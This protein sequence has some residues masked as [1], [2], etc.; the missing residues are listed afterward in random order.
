M[1]VGIIILLGV[2]SCSLSATGRLEPDDIPYVDPEGELNAGHELLKRSFQLPSTGDIN[3]ASLLSGNM[4]VFGVL[5]HDDG[6]GTG[7]KR[8]CEGVLIDEQI[9]LTAQICVPNIPPTGPGKQKWSFTY[10]GQN[11]ELRDLHFF[12][13]PDNKFALIW[14]PVKLT[15]PPDVYAFP[16]WAGDGQSTDIK[17]DIREEFIDNHNVRLSSWYAAKATGDSATNANNIEAALSGCKVDDRDPHIAL[18]CALNAVCG[19]NLV[20]DGATFFKLA[21]TGKIQ[22]VA[23]MGMVI[24]G[25]SGSSCKSLDPRNSV[26]AVLP[27]IGSSRKRKRTGA[28]AGP[29]GKRQKLGNGGVACTDPYLCGIRFR[30]SEVNGIL[31][32]AKQLV[33]SSTKA[34]A[35]AAAGAP[36]PSVAASLNLH[37]DVIPNKAIIGTMNLNGVARLSRTMGDLVQDVFK[38]IFKEADVMLLQEVAFTTP[39][40]QQLQTDLAALGI[41]M[42]ALQGGLTCLYKSA[43]VQSATC[44]GVKLTPTS[45]HEYAQLCKI[46][47]VGKAECFHVFN[48]HLA[49]GIKQDR[50]DQMTDI[51]DRI[52]KLPAGTC[53]EVVLIAGDFNTISIEETERA[54]RSFGNV[55]LHD[56]GRTTPG[57]EFRAQ[58]ALPDDD[59]DGFDPLEINKEFHYDRVIVSES[60]R[61]LHQQFPLSYI[62]P[63]YKVTLE[64][65]SQEERLT[66]LRDTFNA[67]HPV[68]QNQPA[69]RS[70]FLSDH[71]PL[72]FT[73]QNDATFRLGTWNLEHFDPTNGNSNNVDDK[74]KKYNKEFTAIFNEFDVLAVQEIKAAYKKK[75]Q[76]V[77]YTAASNL[78]EISNT[79][80]FNRK[81]VISNKVP[82]LG[83]AYDASINV[84][85]CAN[86]D[87]SAHKY[88]KGTK[89]HRDG[90]SCDFTKN[91]NT[92][93]LVSVHVANEGSSQAAAKLYVNE[94][95]KDKSVLSYVVGD[96]NMNK[97]SGSIN[98]QMKDVAI[99][100]WDFTMAVSKHVRDYVWP[101]IDVNLQVPTGK[102]VPGTSTCAVLNPELAKKA[103]GTYVLAD[104]VPQS[105]MRAFTTWREIS[106]HYPVFIEF[107]S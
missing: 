88:K 65:F 82:E 105:R 77:A 29:G 26:T 79:N 4:K 87:M 45:T 36:K 56:P 52:D 59:E 68:R 55:R 21:H 27:I 34:A 38:K 97:P 81:W 76:F 89:S 1:H 6:S 46:Q 107:D 74:E 23:V 42:A 33:D 10:A 25:E 28:L 48:V 102:D 16:T 92:V 91:G 75:N 24:L 57:K 90:F 31:K 78:R 98:C 7:P 80:N 96:Y 37:T 14:L 103:G 2:F 32:T 83:F 9:V 101:A 44:T 99:P 70:Y 15:S 35:A 13:T 60:T 85:N 51:R 84:A 41:S 93:R 100:G 58:D 20:R 69:V 73:P 62:D 72:F 64:I 18:K 50:Y 61:L 11:I 54:I 66:A 104:E 12:P 5:N 3:S 43:S 53:S 95:R 67:E 106:D 22:G 19:G 40:S 71:L 86:L 49:F 39:E 47:F 30:R 63:V 94:V 17:W 8:I